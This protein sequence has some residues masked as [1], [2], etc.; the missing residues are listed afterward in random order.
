MAIKGPDIHGDY[1]FA[2]PVR[3]EA[4]ASLSFTDEVV[5]FRIGIPG[6]VGGE[7]AE[8]LVDLTLTVASARLASGIVP[9]SDMQ[10]DP[11][12]VYGYHVSVGVGEGCYLVNHGR[13]TIE[14]SV[15]GG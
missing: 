5:A 8:A 9:A 10:L 12:L 11:S 3:V 6:P 15:S 1:G 2:L 4:D 13:L 14:R 7:L